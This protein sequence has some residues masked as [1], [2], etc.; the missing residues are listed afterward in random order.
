MLLCACYGVPGAE[1]AYA[2]TGAGSYNGA[3]SRTVLTDRQYHSPSTRPVLS[4]AMVLQETDEC[5]YQNLK[6]SMYYAPA[7]V[8]TAISTW[9]NIARTVLTTRPPRSVLLNH[10]HTRP[11]CTSAS[12]H[13]LVQGCH[14]RM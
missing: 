10:K 9:H 14:K 12:M 13:F 7:E 8:S 6:A 5:E 11:V 3:I 4:C 2:A 1:T